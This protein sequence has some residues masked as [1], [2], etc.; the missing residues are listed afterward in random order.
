MLGE[1]QRENNKIPVQGEL[2]SGRESICVLLGKWEVGDLLNSSL[3]RR[4][5]KIINRVN[6]KYYIGFASNIA[7]RI[8]QVAGSSQYNTHGGI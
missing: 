2:L 7:I 3:H 5:Y 1:L 6:G 4:V 8:I